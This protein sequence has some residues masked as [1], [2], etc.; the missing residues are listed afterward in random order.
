MVEPGGGAATGAWRIEAVV[1]DAVCRH[2]ARTAPQECC[3]LLIG[4]DGEVRAHHEATNTAERPEARFTVD[5]RDHFAAIRRAREEGLD[6]VGAYHSH[7]ASPAVPSETDRAEA[8]ADFL[9]VIVSLAA[10]EP[11]IRAWQLVAGNFVAV[12]LVRTD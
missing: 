6:V 11:D 10:P 4:V 9:F 2:A 12:R 7:P 5:P 1:V 8:F 3:G